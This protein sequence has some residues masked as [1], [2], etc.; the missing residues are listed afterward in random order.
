MAT[1]GIVLL[2]LTA[3]STSATKEYAGPTLPSD[4]TA[5]VESGPYTHIR[6]L[7]D[8][9]I[10]SLRVAVLPGA[11]TIEMRPAEQEQPYREYLFYSRVTGSAKF[12]AEAGHRYL[13]YVDFIPGPGP[14]DEDKG[15]GY[16][17]I[18]Y[19]LDTSTGKKIANTERLALEVEP[20]S[21]PTGFPTGVPTTPNIMHR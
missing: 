8:Q 13:A 9:R 15:S 21:F 7:D 2:A 20:R 12:V 1:V 6:G 17:W 19:V 10:A 11:H 16:T 5:L 18:G 14:A 3:C 4:Q